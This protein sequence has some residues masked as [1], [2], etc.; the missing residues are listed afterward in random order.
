MRVRMN[1]WWPFGIAFAAIALCGCGEEDLTSVRFTV[2]A[3]GSGSVIVAALRVEPSDR[4]SL[5]PMA[6]GITWE[7]RRAAVVMQK[8]SF[9]DASRVDV[10]G[11]RASLSPAEKGGYLFRLTVPMGESSTWP[12]FVAALGEERD[13]VRDLCGAETGLTAPGK[14]PSFKFTVT[15][16][17]IVA[18]QRCTPDIAAGKPSGA[19]SLGASAKATTGSSENHAYLVVPMAE[20]RRQKAKELVWEV[21]CKG[22]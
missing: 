3:D 21:V 19:F 7:P 8:G 20:V 14:E 11:V 12:G 13:F 5:K 17:G 16:P 22:K 15:M 6:K 18:E 2:R 9:V 1:S 10:A 4:E